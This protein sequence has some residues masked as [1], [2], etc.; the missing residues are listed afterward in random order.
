MNV[1]TVPTS[2]ATTGPCHD[3]GTFPDLSWL[4]VPG[5]I[6]A[7]IVIGIIVYFAIKGSRGL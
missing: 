1:E 5:L 4:A 3:T 2:C 7:V 6:L